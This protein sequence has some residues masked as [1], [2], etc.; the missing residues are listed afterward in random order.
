MRSAFP[1]TDM[2]FAEVLR[3]GLAAGAAAGMAAA[4]V[5]YL[6]VEP[7]IRRALVI[8]EARGAGAGDGH[9]HTHAA[10][11]AEPLVSRTVQVIGGMGT[12][13]VVGC[14]FGLAFA[15][16]FARTRHRLVAT[17][18]HGRAVI[19]AGLGFLTFALLPALQIPSNPPAVGDPATVDRRSLIWVL[20]ILVAVAIVLAVFALDAALVERGLSAPVRSSV[21]AVL[22]LALAA[23]MLLVL[24]GTPD[25]IPDDV[26]PALIWDF[27]L[28]SLA[29]LAAMWSTLG[30]VFGLLVSPRVRR[31]AEVIA[32]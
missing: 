27:R 5:L 22:F 30:L 8:E 17:T 29:Q 2:G 12:A 21:D 9:S 25:P 26:P 10:D 3:R 28:A 20:T 6:V 23:V 11:E 19:L 18:E 1:A 4:V 13:I 24:P 16:V 32:A 14:L 15:V 7:V 31:E